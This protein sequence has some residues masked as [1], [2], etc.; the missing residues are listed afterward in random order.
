MNVVGRE[1]LKKSVNGAG[2]FYSGNIVW[3]SLFLFG[4]NL[5]VQVVE[6]F[7]LRFFPKHMNNLFMQMLHTLL[8]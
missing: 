1:W 5:D 3:S 6:F 8:L 2:L 4:S 7:S